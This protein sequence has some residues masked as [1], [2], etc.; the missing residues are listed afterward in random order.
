MIYIKVTRLNK[1]SVN[2]TAVT[3]PFND[4]ARHAVW[5]LR[6]QVLRG[7]RGLLVSTCGQVQV[8]EA[9]PPQDTHYPVMSS[10]TGISLAN[11]SAEFFPI[12]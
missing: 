11:T 7:V 2:G 10:A 1:I 3:I 5:L 6:E 4:I 8:Y 9:K 12:K